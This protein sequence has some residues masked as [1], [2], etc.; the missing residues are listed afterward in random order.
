MMTDQPEAG[1]RR[2]EDLAFL[3]F[4]CGTA[5]ALRCAQEDICRRCVLKL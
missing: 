4:F 3:F 2:V 5:L 1:P